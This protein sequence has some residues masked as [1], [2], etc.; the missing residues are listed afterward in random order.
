MDH[1]ISPSEY[2]YQLFKK[3]Y[4]KFKGENHIA[5]LLVPDK[6]NPGNKKRR[7][8]SIVGRAHPGT[9]HDLFIELVNYT[10]ERSLNY[11]FVLISSSD[12]S[13]YLENLSTK[14][15]KRLKVVNKGLIK[16]SE[17][18]DILRESYAVFRLDREVTQSGVIPVAYMNETPVIAR[19]IP[20]LRQHVKH[21]YNGYIIPS[22]CNVTELV[23]GMDFVRENFSQLSQGARRSYDEIWAEWNFD[24]YYDWLI[25]KFQ[26]GL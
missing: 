6:K 3:R 5:P 19:D 26:H 16:D 14:G 4:P 8:F 10:A 17:I 20:G 23:E 9:G 25:K 24:R 2:S 1:L 7:F 15:R 18:N 21:K 12:I 13:K 22:N 11:E